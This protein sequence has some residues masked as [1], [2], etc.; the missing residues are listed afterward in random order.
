MERNIKIVV[1]I[2]NKGFFSFRC[3]SEKM[4]YMEGLRFDSKGAAVKVIRMTQLDASMDDRYKREERDGKFYFNFVAAN[5]HPMTVS[6]FFAS[7]AGMEGCIL[8]MKKYLKDARIEFE[9]DC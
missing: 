7:E 4:V 3:C 5:G 6:P 1:Y 8:M 2:D 9:G